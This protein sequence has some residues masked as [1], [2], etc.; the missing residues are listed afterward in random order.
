VQKK[1]LILLLQTVSGQ[2]PGTPDGSLGLFL[3]AA[4]FADDGQKSFPLA[5]GQ[6]G[7]VLG[8]GGAGGDELV[9][10]SHLSEL[11]YI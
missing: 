11:V 9:L 4:A 8:E 6:A 3:P 10:S 1:V 2:H 7:L 5:G